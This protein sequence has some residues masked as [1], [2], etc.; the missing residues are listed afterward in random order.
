MKKKIFTLLTLLATVCSGAWA[1]GEWSIDFT[2]IGGNYPD[3][4]GVTISSS[5]A[6]IGGTT[7]GTC[8]VKEEALNENFVLQTGTTWMIRQANGLYQGNG[9]G[10]A[11]GM[12]GCTAGQIITIVGTGNPNPSTNAT[13]KS[14]DGNTYV[15]TVTADGDVKFTPARYLY[16]TSIS[17]ANPSAT[18][19]EYTVKY[20]DEEGNEIKTS[21]N[22]EGEAGD[23]ITLTSTEKASF[24]NGEG[25]KKYIY[26]SDD[27]ESKTIAGDGSTV[28]TITF[29]EAATYTYSVANN[30]G[31]AIASGSA[32]EGDD[33][34]FY[35]SYFVYKDNKFYESP[36]LSSGTL[37]YG[38]GKISAIAA[39]TEITVSYTEEESTNVVFFSEAENL[40][41]IIDYEDT[42][43]NGR[44]S[45]GKVGYYGEQTA[46]VNLPAGKYT[47]TSASRYG[48]TTFTAGE[49]DVYTL[50]SEG[51]VVTT[52]SDEFT[53]TEATDIKISAGDTK[54]YFDYV[55]IRK[56]GDIVPMTITSA[57]WA[58]FSST[59]EVA[60]PKGVTAY[61]ASA[62]DGSSV[63]LTE[64][65]GGYIPA[66][67]GVI[68]SGDEGIYGAEITTTGATV[69]GT[70]L[71]QAWTT[72][73][74]PT[75]ETYYTLAAGPTFK[76]SK[77]G[78][79]AAGKAYLVIPAGA[80]E[81]SVNFGETTGINQIDNG[82]L[83]IDNSYYNIAGQRVAQPTKGLYI[84]NG[85]KVVVK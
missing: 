22:G 32:F 30:L 37:S 59:S 39:N 75:A 33:V 72:S 80:R 26:K 55:I 18:A 46:I 79:L 84:V 35:I 50:T 19:V 60:I 3:K 82:Q 24:T 25:T 34:Y 43:V 45:N 4:T 8:T 49:T 58:S 14:Q 23:N 2:A 15:Y 11:M 61:Y 54:N 51:S 71:L 70:N 29:K 44:M 27:S 17:V 16:F 76:E 77:G 63:T 73:G 85:K 81:L 28:V 41:G 47:I 31:D 42:N 6:T 53:L 64:I 52:T 21:T 65:E 10:R 74:T 38:Q 20:V 48:T 40:T 5:V 9:G 66:N 7:M 56:T 83:T 36:S 68:I 57:G 78:V 62:S 69:A 67:T 12:L 1:T 13:L